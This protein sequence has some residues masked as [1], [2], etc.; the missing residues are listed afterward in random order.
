[1]FIEGAVAEGIGH[2]T[3]RVVQPQVGELLERSET[4]KRIDA[5]KPT[6]DGHDLFRETYGQ[7]SD[8]PNLPVFQNF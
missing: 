2:V 4:P 3:N 7:H 8:M 5:V 1:M 6:I